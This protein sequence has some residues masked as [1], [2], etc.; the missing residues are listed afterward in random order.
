MAATKHFTTLIA[1]I[2]VSLLLFSCSKKLS[3]SEAEKQ[4]K[5]NMQ[6]PHD[7][8]RDFNLKEKKAYVQW[9]EYDLNYIL[10]K[11]DI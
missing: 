6:L 9:M 5:Q 10:E 8:F 7:E 4:I 11:L 3:R 2:L 1:L